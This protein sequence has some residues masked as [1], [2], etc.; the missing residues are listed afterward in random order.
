MKDN[1]K[2]ID[3]VAGAVVDTG[4]LGLLFVLLAWAVWALGM[5]IAWVAL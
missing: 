3:L 2:W 4:C 1:G 5:L